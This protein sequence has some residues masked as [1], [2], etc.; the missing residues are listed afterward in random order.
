MINQVALDDVSFV[1]RRDKEVFYSG[2]FT[3]D[4]LIAL[5]EQTDVTE[6]TVNYEYYPQ[7]HSL[8]WSVQVY[9]PNMV[10]GMGLMETSLM[11]AV[12][13][14]MILGWLAERDY[15]DRQ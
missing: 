13:G 10:G 2:D 3:D 5:V 15:H 14:A 8:Q 1:R 4:E 12:A 6:I 7:N 9:S 11:R